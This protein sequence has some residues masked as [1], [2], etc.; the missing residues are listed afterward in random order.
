LQSANTPGREHEARPPARER[1]H[2]LHEANASEA[3]RCTAHA[4]QH[5]CWR[6]QNVAEADLREARALANLENA[7][8]K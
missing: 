2:G 8:V 6:R 4:K 5:G 3:Q 1:Q 7:E